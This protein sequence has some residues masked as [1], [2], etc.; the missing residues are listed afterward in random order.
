MKKIIFI[1]V[2][3]TMF[4]GCV[5]DDNNSTVTLTDT[6][7]VLNASEKISYP[8]FTPWWAK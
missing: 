8:Y 2:L 4:S 1:A 5:I 7:K 6:N 3:L